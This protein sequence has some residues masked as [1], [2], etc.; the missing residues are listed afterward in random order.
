MGVD[1]LKASRYPWDRTLEWLD[2]SGIALFFWNRLK[3]LSIE[4][5][6]P[7]EIGERLER[8][9]ADH[10]LRVAEMVAEFD[11]I[12]QCWESAGVKYAA[13]KGLVLTPE[14]CPD[15]FLR[16]TYDYDYLLPCGSMTTAEEVLRRAGYVRKED[17]V[18]H[19][20]VYFHKAHRPRLPLSGDD[21]YSASFPRTIELHCLFWDPDELKIPLEIQADPMGHLELRHLPVPSSRQG[22]SW[23]ERPVCFYALAEEHGLLFQVLH[24]FRHILQDW[25]RLCSL[26]DIA[27]F[28]HHRGRDN[29]FWDRFFELLEHDRE[30]PEIAGVVFLLAAGLFGAQ[31]PSVVAGQITGCLRRPLVSWVDHYGMDS[32]LQNF[33]DNKFSL[34]LHREFVRDDATWRTILRSRLFPLHRPNQAVRATSRGI[35]SR[36]AA[37]WK[38]RDYIARRLKHHLAATVRYVLESARWE[39]ARTRNR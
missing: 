7:P 35:R 28:L 10:R 30:L 21:L 8:N 4:K 31:I 14:Y 36:W 19:P 11:A 22:S 39:R 23:P 27:Y 17:P 13:L 33:S 38:Q 24:A 15:I 9:L 25:C 1:R 12:N 37:S 18:K 26:L 2:H 34:F 16:T 5:A 3:N 20:V 29:D 6:I 32:A